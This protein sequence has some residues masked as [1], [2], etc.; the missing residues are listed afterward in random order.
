M[1]RYKDKASADK[2]TAEP[3]FKELFAKFEQEGI[4]AKA[5]YLAQTVSKEGFDLDRKL[6]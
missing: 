4:M 3:H 5:P 6:I 2:H 1:R